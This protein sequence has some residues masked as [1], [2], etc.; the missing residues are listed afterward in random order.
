MAPEGMPPQG[1]QQGGSM[2]PQMEA[3]L[4]QVQSM[5]QQG[6]PPN[7]IIGGLLQNGIP[8]EIIMQI[9]MQVGLVQDEQQASEMIQ[10]E[11]A[12]MQQAQQ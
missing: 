12:N 7:V 9:I 1:G 6:A 11:M 5:V 4:Q 8:P 10:Q 3:L 2:D